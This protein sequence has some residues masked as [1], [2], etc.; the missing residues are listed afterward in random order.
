[1]KTLS[2]SCRCGQSGNRGF[3][4]VKLS[5]AETTLLPKVYTSRYFYCSMF[6]LAIQILS[7]QFNFTDINVVFIIKFESCIQ[8]KLKIFVCRKM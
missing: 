1:M 5:Q 8:F 4:L 7:F 6:G 2:K 3:G